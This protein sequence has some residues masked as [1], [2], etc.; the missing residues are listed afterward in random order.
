[1]RQAKVVVMQNPA[2]WWEARLIGPHGKFEAWLVHG[3]KRKH[4]AI[5][6][7]Q[8]VKLLMASAKLVID[9]TIREND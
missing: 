7:A 9:D 6:A 5:R 4:T 3:H 2:G 1:M 8:R